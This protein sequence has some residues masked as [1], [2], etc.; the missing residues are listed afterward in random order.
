MAFSFISPKRVISGA[1]CLDE[2]LLH[3]SGHGHNALV[4]AGKSAEKSGAVSR[5]CRMMDGLKIGHVIFSGVTGEPDDVMISAGVEAYRAGSCDMLIAVGGGSQIDAMKAI[6]L[7][8]ESGG[9]ISD[10]AAGKGATNDAINHMPFMAAVPTTAGTGSEVTKFTIVT[11]TESGAKLLISDEALIPDLA[12]VDPELTLSM[13]EKVTVSTGLDALTHAIESYTSRK[14]QPLSDTLA[15]S[16]VRRIFDNIGRAVDT[17]NDINA[18]E[19][20]SIAALEAG[21]SFNNSSVTIVHGMSRP[22][23]AHF[24]VPHGMSNAILLPSCLEFAKNGAEKKFA[25]LGRAIGAA[26][27]VNTDKIAAQR[28]V[29]AV[30]LLTMSLGVSSLESYGIDKG[31]F[32]GAIDVMTEEALASGSPA[33]TIREVAAED[34]KTIYRNLWP[35]QIHM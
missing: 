12:V 20:M 10:Y 16:A 18:R 35:E 7:L 6:A 32:I 24:R 5:I 27:S 9:K 23:G 29:D 8:T 15:L 4:V 13:P 30:R 26:M 31:E 21:L 1:G 17:P 34:I 25:D 2:L 14:A 22:I 3:L 33:N 19:Q 11:D 28:F